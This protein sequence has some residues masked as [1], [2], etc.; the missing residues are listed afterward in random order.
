MPIRRSGTGTR[1]T[2][3]TLSFKLPRFRDR[4]ADPTVGIMISIGA[5]EL[6]FHT[7]V[8]TKE[9]IRRLGSGSRSMKENLNYKLS[10]RT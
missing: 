2:Q 10:R 3:E 5:G 7:H 9:R 6:G 4:N 8:V 1:S